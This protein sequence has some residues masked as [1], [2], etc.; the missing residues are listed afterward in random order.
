MAQRF[1]H[2]TQIFSVTLNLQYK[3]LIPF[4]HIKQFVSFSF[5]LILNNSPHHTI[6]LPP[7]TTKASKQAK[8][9][10]VLEQQQQ[11]CLNYYISQQVVC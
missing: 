10:K 11:K 7:P 6:D 2:L 1:G 9:Y 5:I 3:L 4:H 8:T